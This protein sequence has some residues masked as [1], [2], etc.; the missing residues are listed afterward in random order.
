MNVKYRDITLDFFFNYRTIHIGKFVLNL[1]HF[2][3]LKCP[4][5]NFCVNLTQEY[6]AK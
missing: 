2:T 3:C 4:H 1:T 6:V 5:S